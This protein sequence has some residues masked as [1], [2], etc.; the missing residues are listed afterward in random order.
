MT[1]RLKR[2]LTLTVGCVLLAA[3]AGTNR[4][5]AQQGCTLA[6]L[7]GPYGYAL[8]GSFYDSRGFQGLYASA[9]RLVTDGNGAITSGAE[10][11]NVDGTL[12]RR[13]YTGSYTINSDC[14]GTMTIQSGTA[15]AHGDI[16]LVNGG[17]ELNFVQ[18]DTDIIFSGV[19]KAQ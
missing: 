14:T 19:M 15:F 3:V 8:G 7:T 17:K 2:V 13:N 10:T 12:V 5:K 1:I 11:Q 6:T 16:V 4:T 9:G 18:T